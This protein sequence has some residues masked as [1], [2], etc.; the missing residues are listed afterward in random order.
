MGARPAL[1]VEYGQ[2]PGINNA[3][4][5][6]NTATGPSPANHWILDSGY[7]PGPDLNRAAKD[8]SV[9]TI[10]LVLAGAFS[11]IVKTD[12]SGSDRLQL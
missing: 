4:H 7:T 5:P 9:F 2:V 6:A 10:I 3:P 1:A 12:G 11:V 8:P